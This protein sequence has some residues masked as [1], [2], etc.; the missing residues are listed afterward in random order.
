[1]KYLFALALALFSPVQALAALTY[2][3]RF[4]MQ[5]RDYDEETNKAGTE[6]FMR[7]Y[8]QR[9]RLDFQGKQND[10]VSYRLRL[11]FNQPAA[12]KV[13]AGTSQPTVNERDSLGAWIDHASVTQKIYEFGFLTLGKFASDIG[14][15]EGAAVAD[16]YVLSSTYAR[17]TTAGLTG[18]EDFQFYT[19]LKVG[20][21]FMDHEVSL[22]I[23]NAEP[24]DHTVG[25]KFSQN[26]P[27]LGIVWKG[28][29]ADG[30]YLPLFAYHQ[31]PGAPGSTTGGKLSF[32]SLGN[33]LQLDDLLI[34]V[35]FLKNDYRDDLPGAQTV[36]SAIV[37]SFGFKLGSLTPK[38]QVNQGNIEARAAAGATDT[39]TKRTSTALAVEFVPDLKDRFRYHAAIA[40][41]ELEVVGAAKTEKISELILGARLL[42]DFLKN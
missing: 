26:K 41:T 23:A 20:A 8:I 2:D 35:D 42:G 36:N 15:Y 39:K 4:D 16:R 11:R 27:A 22:H 31:L 14:G 19:G 30:V 32:L 1:M 9:G 17:S 5:S 21:A 34:D 6:D 12:G 33:R 37:T 25:G 18:S 28:N 3:F 7:F 40:R 38:L 24:V 10:D 13:D 29:F